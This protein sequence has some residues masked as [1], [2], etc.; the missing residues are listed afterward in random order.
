[1]HPTNWAEQKKGRKP[2][3]RGPSYNGALTGAV[4]LHCDFVSRCVVR[5]TVHERS[6]Q[7]N[8]ATTRL[9]KFSGSVGSGS[10]DTSNPGPSSRTMNVAVSQVNSV[11]T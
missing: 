4:F 8:A 5:H 6:Y 3:P 11:V 1:M 9:Q 10:S 7:H 2:R